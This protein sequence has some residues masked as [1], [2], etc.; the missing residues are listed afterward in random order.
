MRQKLALYADLTAVGLV[1]I[2]PFY[3]VLMSSVK[4]RDGMAMA[5]PAFYPAEVDRVQLSISLAGRVARYG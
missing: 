4:S 2:F 1:L 3:W 5:P